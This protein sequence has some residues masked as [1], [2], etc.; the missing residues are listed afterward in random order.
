MTSTLHTKFLGITIEN[1]LLWNIHLNQ[2]I[3]KSS[4][5]CFV[6]GT[7][8]SSVLTDTQIKVSHAYFT[9]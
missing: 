5:A 1:M 8:K 3:T 4:R 2:L 7:F 6:I 9:H